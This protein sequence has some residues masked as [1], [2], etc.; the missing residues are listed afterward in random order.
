MRMLSEIEADIVEC[1]ARLEEVKGTKTEVY[2]RIVGYY[3]NMDHFNQGK[4][5]ELRERVMFK[6]PGVAGET[7]KE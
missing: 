5:S 4:K 1:R 2:T 7:I 6:L 3:R